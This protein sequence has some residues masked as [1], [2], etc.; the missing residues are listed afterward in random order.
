[1]FW[2]FLVAVATALVFIKLGALSVW[3]GVLF[4]SENFTYHVAPAH[5][6]PPGEGNQ[7]VQTR[8]C[9][10]HACA[11]NASCTLNT[12]FVYTRHQH[13]CAKP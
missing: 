1:M 10:T 5:C 9:R 7:T 12:G 13:V 4:L 11:W 2:M 8:T 6:C 3:V